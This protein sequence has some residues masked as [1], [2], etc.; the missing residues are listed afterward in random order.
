MDVLR[1]PDAIGCGVSYGMMDINK[2]TASVV[3][4][5]AVC[6]GIIV[7]LAQAYGGLL[8]EVPPHTCPSPSPCTGALQHAVLGC[9]WSSARSTTV[10]FSLPPS[11]PPA[12]P[13]GH[14]PAPLPARARLCDELP[15]GV[16]S[17]AALRA[18]A[19]HGLV[20]RWGDGVGVQLIKL[21]IAGLV[22]MH[23]VDPACQAGIYV[24]DFCV[25]GGL[26]LGKALVGYGLTVFAG[27]QSYLAYNQRQH[28]LTWFPTGLSLLW[29]SW[30]PN[31]MVEPTLT[32]AALARARRDVLRGMLRRRGLPTSGTK[33]ILVARLLGV[34]VVQLRRFQRGYSLSAVSSI[35]IKN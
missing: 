4:V 1:C 25:Q 12:P 29:P 14:T 31:A 18:Y 3:C 34:E 6:T 8:A 7:L 20:P 21:G 26:G 33:A 10:P 35:T 9:P 5:A 17:Q 22:A 27:R 11:L 28:A 15:D 19:R 24:Y 23:S 30:L 32:Q 16:Y 2:T 13:L